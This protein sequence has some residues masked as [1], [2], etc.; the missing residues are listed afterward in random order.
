MFEI[1]VRYNESGIDNDVCTYTLT[2]KEAFML[3]YLEYPNSVEINIRK[4][5]RNVKTI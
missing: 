1:K 5:D 2:L 4:I 3:V